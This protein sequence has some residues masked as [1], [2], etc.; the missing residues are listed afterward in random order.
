MTEK[1]VYPATKNQGMYKI[2]EDSMNKLIRLLHS[3]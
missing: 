2:A 1:N 3:A